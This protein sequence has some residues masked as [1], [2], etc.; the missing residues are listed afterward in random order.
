MGFLDFQDSF[1]KRRQ[2]EGDM[3][4]FFLQAPRWSVIEGTPDQMVSMPLRL[5]GEERR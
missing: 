2:I 5:S 4:P 1:F 3:P